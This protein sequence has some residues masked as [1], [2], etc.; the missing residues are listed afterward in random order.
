MLM[1]FVYVLQSKK[2]S[3][4]Y[5][6][7]TNDLERR[8][9]EHNKGLVTY[10]ATWRPWKLIYYEVFPNKEDALERERYL[11]SGW[12]RRHIKKVLRHYFQNESK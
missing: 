2:D 4:P 1:Y 3:R 12:G 9:K 7:F 10:S 11:K 6:G 5:K 8:L